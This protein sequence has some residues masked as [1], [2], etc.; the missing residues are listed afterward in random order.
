[1]NIAIFFMMEDNGGESDPENKGLA[2]TTELL[3]Q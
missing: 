1:M 3:L 2:L